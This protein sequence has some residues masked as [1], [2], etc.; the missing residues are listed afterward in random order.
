MRPLGVALTALVLSAPIGAQ[1]VPGSDPSS[2]ADWESL[3]E[4][5]ALR[6]A[7][8]ESV[9]M[10]YSAEVLGEGPAGGIGQ[11]AQDPQPATETGWWRMEGRRFAFRREVWSD[12]V[13]QQVQLTWDGVRCSV[14]SV[15]PRLMERPEDDPDVFPSLLEIHPHPAQPA[16]VDVPYLP[17]QFG[18]TFNAE[19][20]SDWSKATADVQVLGREDVDGV[21]CLLVL[22]DLMG[23][24]HGDDGEYV[25]P[26][27]L[28]F[29]DR[30][31]LLARR[32]VS[33]VHDPDE[34][35]ELPRIGPSRTFGG[36][37]FRPIAMWALATTQRINGAWLP[38]SGEY[39]RATATG[40]QRVAVRVEE[41]ARW[42]G[43][44]PVDVFT[45]EPPPGTQLIDYVEGRNTKLSAGPGD[46]ER[47]Q[48][49]RDG[50][51]AALGDLDRIVGTH[52]AEA[53]TKDDAAGLITL[54]S[55]AAFDGS[56]CGPNALFLLLAHLG[57][58]APLGALVDDLPPAHR[59]LGRTNLVTLDR[60]AASRLRSVSVHDDSGDPSGWPGL[61]FVAHL[62]EGDHDHFALACMLPE[63]HEQAGDVWLC[64]PPAAPAVMSIEAFR[65]S[66][67]GAALLVGDGLCDWSDSVGRMALLRRLALGGLG[68][69]LLAAVFRFRLRGRQIL[70]RLTRVP[71]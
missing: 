70:G 31:T 41:G 64:S 37:L 54:E 50:L 17:A 51:L 19:R 67:S 68:L 45:L 36:R 49:R 44:A 14:L 1:S 5:L 33:F 30:E 46:Q 16:L 9:W 40:V 29:D 55:M 10:P 42:N 26:W 13:P 47:W 7:A 6:D 38:L 15:L 23:P 69:I 20:W 63:G 62:T 25:Q 34:G 18:L 3:Q 58:Q 66:W 52:R 65:S 71:S 53:F 48:R 27:L 32:K 2:V 59:S 60:L 22:V 61:P 11:G 56:S 12:G 8:F 28:W 39:R 4:L 43:P 24:G 21:D 35:V 57:A